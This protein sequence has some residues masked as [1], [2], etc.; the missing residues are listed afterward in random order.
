MNFHAERAT[1]FCTV[2]C[3]WMIVV[4]ATAPAAEAEKQASTFYSPSVLDGNPKASFSDIQ[5]NIEKR[6]FQD[7]TANKHKILSNYPQQEIS[8]AT[9]RQ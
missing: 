9:R 7:S 2:L 4:A 6:I 3:A 5:R 8:L 1:R